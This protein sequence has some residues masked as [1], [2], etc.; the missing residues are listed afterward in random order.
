MKFTTTET[1]ETEYDVIVVGAGMARNLRG[2]NSAR[3]L[4]SLSEHERETVAAKLL[5][6]LSDEA[7]ARVTAPWTSESQ[8]TADA[9]R[10]AGYDP[11]ET[12]AAEVINCLHEGYLE[13]DKLRQS[14]WEKYERASGN[15]ELARAQLREWRETVGAAEVIEKLSGATLGDV[16][17]PYESIGG[18]LA[19]LESAMASAHGRDYTMPADTAIESIMMLIKQRDTARQAQREAVSESQRLLERAERAERERDGHESAAEHLGKALDDKQRDLN[20]A[21]L[22]LHSKAL[23]VEK[24]EDDLRTARAQL[25]TTENVC[26]TLRAEA[27]RERQ[28][29]TRAE[30]AVAE[31]EQCPRCGS[32]APH[33][34]PAVQ[35]GGEVQPCRDAWH[36]RVTPQNTPEKIRETQELIAKLDANKPA[37]PTPEWEH[38]DPAVLANVFPEAP[39][40]TPRIDRAPDPGGEWFSATIEQPQ[41]RGEG[42]CKRCAGDGTICVFSKWNHPC[43]DCNGTG[44]APEQPSPRKPCD[45]GETYEMPAAPPGDTPEAIA[46]DAWR[47]SVGDFDL[48]VAE[49]AARIRA[50]VAAELQWVADRCERSKVGDKEHAQYDETLDYAAEVARRRIRELEAKG[51]KKG[52]PK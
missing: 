38:V 3:P 14:H 20:G 28:R 43:P 30:T 2:M 42:K 51:G 21:E 45:D 46:L 1:T 40:H 47:A 26:R 17:K 18:T 37:E 12:G 25:R 22:R 10:A 24:L 13:S 32:T 44:R 35:E 31:P 39:E 8:A 15:L 41:A 19:E 4:E 23:R 50:L 27:E 34:H 33:L 6:S 29:A 49:V 48:S 36:K 52:G 11:D 5:E 16:S 9:I 7:R